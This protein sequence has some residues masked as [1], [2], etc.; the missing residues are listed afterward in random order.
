MINIERYSLILHCKEGITRINLE[1]LA[2]CEAGRR[3]LFFHL[4]NE[5]VLESTGS[6][7]ELYRKLLAYENFIRPNRSYLINMEYI[8]NISCKAIVM[9]DHAEIPI[10]HGKYSEIKNHYLEYAFNREKV[11]LL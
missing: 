7:D 3:R 2:Y 10:P 4:E 6:M 9:D 1:K 8:Q 5:K 11:F